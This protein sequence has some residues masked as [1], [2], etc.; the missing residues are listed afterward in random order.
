MTQKTLA[1]SSAMDIMSEIP[2]YRET[3]FGRE[4]MP[5]PRTNVAFKV[6][7][8]PYRRRFAMSEITK[9]S[10]SR[11]EF[12]KTTGRIAAVSALAAGAVPRILKDREY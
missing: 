7:T 1:K 10:T 8:I 9:K 2:I 12:L 6:N 5:T 3:T 11:R 4:Q